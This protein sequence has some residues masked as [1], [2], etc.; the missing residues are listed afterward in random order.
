M[1]AFWNATKFKRPS[2][3]PSRFKTIKKPLKSLS[4]FTSRHS[5]LMKNS[6]TF[7]GRSWKVCEL[8]LKLNSELQKLW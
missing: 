8:R 1:N 4:Q 3:I 7:C 5:S 6:L 2:L